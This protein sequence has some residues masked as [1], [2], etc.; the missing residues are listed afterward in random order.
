MERFGSDKPDLRFGMEL[1][2]ISDTV[3]NIPFP[4]FTDALANGGSVRAIVVSGG[5]SMTRKEI[6]AFTET[7]KTY[8]AKGMAWLVPSEPARGSFLKFLDETAIQAIAK[9]TGA[10]QNDLILIVADQNAIVFNALGAVR[11][12][13]AR[14]LSLIDESEFN[15]LWVTEFPLLEYDAEANRY[16]A[17]HHP[18]TNPMDE[19]LEYLDTDPGRVRA[20]AYDVILNGVELGG[21]SIRI[22]DQALQ[23]KMFSLLGFTEE[24]AHAQFGFLLDA[25]GYGVPPH[26][27]LALGL[28]RMIMLMAGAKSIRDVIAFPKVQNSSDLMTEAPAPVAQNQLDD[29]GI[30]IA[31]D[32]ENA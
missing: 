26:G 4:V 20:K 21:G 29:L 22:H 27:G 30:A 9:A 24:E 2:N 8:Q 5:A 17:M 15:L 28:D 1:A 10:T 31:E 13:V 18:F 32:I 3:K 6:D 16:V 7:A 11:C 19:D 23:K 25:F 12:E 14:K